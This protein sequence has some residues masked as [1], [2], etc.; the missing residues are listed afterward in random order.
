MNAALNLCRAH[1]LAPIDKEVEIGNDW[2]LTQ[3]D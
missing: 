3:S 1:A 2:S